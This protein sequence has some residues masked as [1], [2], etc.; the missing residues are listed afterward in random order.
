VGELS[1]FVLLRHGATR[2]G[3]LRHWS[4]VGSASRSLRVR[5][6]AGSDGVASPV[7]RGRSGRANL[8]GLSR[9]TARSPEK[10]LELENKEPT[11][12]KLLVG[13]HSAWL[14]LFNKTQVVM[15]SVSSLSDYF[16]LNSQ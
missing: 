3:L 1:R 10:L 2:D 14:Y 4:H 6:D 13:S 9:G 5:L 16:Y 11:T 8:G 12:K 15:K 7:A